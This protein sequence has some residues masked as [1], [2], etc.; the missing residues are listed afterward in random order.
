MSFSLVY[1]V[2]RFFYRIFDFLRDWY[3]G[4][5]LW[6]SHRSLNFLERLDRFFALKVTF[7]YWF[8][9]LYQDY[10]F[11][12]YVLGF[13]FRTVRL[14]AACL[15]YLAFAIISWVFYLAWAA[16]PVYLVYKIIYGK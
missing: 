13:F 5:F 7:R 11:I 16:I 10:S 2:Q 1:L 15:V 9:P 4:G 3:V 6:F 8:K 14:L 12:G